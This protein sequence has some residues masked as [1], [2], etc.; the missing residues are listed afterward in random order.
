MRPR[1]DVANAVAENAKSKLS[2]EEL[3]PAAEPAKLS[4]SAPLWTP[5]S[6]TW[7][8]GAIDWG[9]AA[10]EAHASCDDGGTCAWWDGISGWGGEAE[11]VVLAARTKLNS[12]ATIFQPKI[13][14]QV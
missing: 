10:G 5:G 9:A 4:A 6:L 11:D 3:V 8:D 7:W 12:K 13:F 14:H 2:L 1:K